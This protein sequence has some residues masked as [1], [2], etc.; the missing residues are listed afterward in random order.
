MVVCYHEAGPVPIL[1]DPVHPTIPYGY[2]PQSSPAY[3]CAR[4]DK[5]QNSC[6]GSE[7]FIVDVW[8]IHQSSPVT[9]RADNEGTSDCDTPPESH[10]T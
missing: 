4:P 8:A 3:P 5:R 2:I 1:R 9:A 6:D 10:H 7:L